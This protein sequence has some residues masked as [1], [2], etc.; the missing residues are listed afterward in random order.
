MLTLDRLQPLPYQVRV[1]AFL[2]EREP[3]LW[4]WGSSAEAENEYVRQ[5]RTSLLKGTYRLGADGHAELIERCTAVA[6]RLGIT[7]PIT[8]YQSIGGTEMNAGLY[9]LPGEAHVVF[10]GA[11]L[12][13]LQGPEI[14]A[15]LAHELAHHR[16]W[17]HQ[18]RDFLVADRLLSAA[19]SDARAATS[20]VQ[21]AR[22][23]RLYTEIYAD[24]GA[25]VGSGQ[26]DV[27]VAAL[28]KMATGLPQVSATS[29]LRQADEILADGGSSEGY[30]HPEM[31]IRARALRL[32]S[33]DDVSVDA[34]LARTIEGELALDELDLLSQMRLAELTRRFVGHLLRPEW[35]RTPP[36]LAHARSFFPE[37]SAAAIAPDAE[38]TRDL[39]FTDIATLDYFCFLLLDFARV[40]RDLETQ[41]LAHG[42]CIAE[43]LGMLERFTK[44]VATELQFNKRELTKL[45]KEAAALAPRAGRTP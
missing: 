32:W 34:W 1:V 39:A 31:F 2:K 44:L 26:L 22:R 7:V 6:A 30:D 43:E 42:Y 29:Y 27:A 4:R 20:H 12:N 16:L 23:F 37:F 15:V 45:K 28:V 36:V 25:L 24:R 13:T 18:G 21:T 9:Y 35:M 8:L 5:V 38:L 10:T 40:D 19:A 33:E 3:E 11:V 17:E 41:P 14:D